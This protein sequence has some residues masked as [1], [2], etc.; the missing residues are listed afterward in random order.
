MIV[1]DIIMSRWA[2]A[3]GPERGRAGEARAR[4]HMIIRWERERRVGRGAGERFVMREGGR[5]ESLEWCGE[6]AGCTHELMS[7]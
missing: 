6:R 7:V 5:R 1:T 3:E 2:R 4:Q